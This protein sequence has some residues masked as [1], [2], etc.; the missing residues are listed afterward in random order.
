MHIWILRELQFLVSSDTR[1]AG[2]SVIKRKTK[3]CKL[4][5]KHNNS[6]YILT[7][8]FDRNFKHLILLLVNTMGCPQLK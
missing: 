1:L 8:V 2:S 3:C 4:P 6:A 7:V 5:S